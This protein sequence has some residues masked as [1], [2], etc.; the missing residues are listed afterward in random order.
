MEAILRLGGEVLGYGWKQDVSAGQRVTDGEVEVG[1]VAPLPFGP[2][3][4]GTAF[5][6]TELT[7]VHEDAYL[8]AGT[9]FA[10]APHVDGT[11]VE[12]S[13]IEED[14]AVADIAGAPAGAFPV[15]FLGARRDVVGRRRNDGRDEG[16]IGG[17][18]GEGA[19][20]RGGGVR[21]LGG[22]ESARVH[23]AEEGRAMQR[24]EAAAKGA[25]FD[26]PAEGGAGGGGAGERVWGGQADEDLLQELVGNGRQRRRGHGG[27][28]GR[29]GSRVRVGVRGSGSDE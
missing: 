11:G 2:R 23:E 3:R 7:G 12:G 1:S 9:V 24:A 27:G 8:T 4:A 20:E 25:A 21:R 13:P 28:A 17:G 15:V 14:A 22:V 19:G 18:G 29:R 10:V 5:F 6:V 16:E 26:D